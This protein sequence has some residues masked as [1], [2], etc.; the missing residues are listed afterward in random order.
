MTIEKKVGQLIKKYAT[1]NPFEIA[2]FMGV[3][4]TYVPLGSSYGFFTH[5]FRTFI[6]HINEA[7]SYEKQLYTLMHELGHITLH[8]EINSAFLKANT[9]YIT[10]RYESEAHEFAIELFYKQ[11]ELKNISLKEATNKYGIPEPLLK[12]KFYN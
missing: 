3:E 5:Y 4:I 11:D 12:K 8:P 2:R 7:L 10:D 6:I 1:S 9:F